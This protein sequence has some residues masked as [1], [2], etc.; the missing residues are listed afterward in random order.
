MLVVCLNAGNYLKRGREYVVKLHNGVRRHLGG[1]FGFICF[2]DDG[3][4]YPDGIAKRELPKSG[5]KGWWNKV[6]LFSP[7]VFGDGERVLYFDL[8]TLIVGPIG[9]IAAYSGRFA[10]LGPYANV[11][12]PFDGNQSGVMAW[13]GGFGDEIWR[14]FASLGNP[15]VPGG[16]QAFLN[17]LNLGPDVWQQMF[18]GR[19]ASFKWECMGGLPDSVSVCGFH[20]LPRPH[21]CGGWVRDHWR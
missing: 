17:H 5:L 7:G 1:E 16:D 18:P 21:Q 12:P 20:G 15:D 4:P 19:F 8:D 6:S 11:L 9:D 3:E 10:M 2:T 13:A 14:T